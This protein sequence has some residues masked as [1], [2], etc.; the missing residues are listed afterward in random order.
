MTPT[1]PVSSRP[2]VPDPSLPDEAREAA[3]RAAFRVGG[4]EDSLSDH[5][6]LE[7]LGSYLDAHHPRPDLTPPWQGGTT[8]PTDADNYFARL[9]DRTTHAAMLMLGSGLDHSMPGVAFPGEVTLRELP[10]LRSCICEPSQPIGRWAIALRGGWWYGSGTARDIAWRPLVAGVAELSG[11]TILDVDYPLLPDAPLA[12]VL[13]TVHAATAYAR[14]KSAGPLAFWGVD[15]GA[16][17]ALMA[18]RAEQEARALVLSEPVLDGLEGL[19][20]AFGVVPPLLPAAQWPRTLVQLAAHDEVT[21]PPRELLQGAEVKEYVSR[22]WICTPEVARRKAEDV[23][24]F[25]RR[26]L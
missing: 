13:H 26:E 9:P 21:E 10:D 4:W 8:A 19:D 14:E 2:P 3:E 20:P 16:A 12:E 15:T 5:E 6:Q 11:L 23:A 1:P 22:H 7:Q 24:E 25:L 17:L 18:A